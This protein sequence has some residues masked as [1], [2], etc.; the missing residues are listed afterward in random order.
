MHVKCRLGLREI[1]AFIIALFLIVLSFDTTRADVVVLLDN[2]L[3]I[4]D[5]SKTYKEDMMDFLRASGE[6]RVYFAPIGETQ[7]DP[8]SLP[9]SSSDT[10]GLKKRI[11]NVFT[12]MDT[13][14]KITESFN[15][16]K[17]IASK[18]EV[19]RIV[20]VSDMAPDD[21]VQGNRW[22]FDI[23]DLKDLKECIRILEDWASK[24]KLVIY[25]LG[26]SRKPVFYTEKELQAFSG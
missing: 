13:K 16:I 24:K 1:T 7:Y 6:T 20:I 14:T 2:S 9:D 25:L 12:F 4:H 5:L 10:S 22:D 8:N 17:D 3:S 19:D 15:R 26:W 11:N 18:S 21:Q 23:K